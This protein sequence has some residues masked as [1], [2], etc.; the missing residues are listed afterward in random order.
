MKIRNQILPFQNFKKTIQ[1]TQQQ[2]KTDSANRL[3][4]LEKNNEFLPIEF[5][6]IDQLIVNKIKGTANN[7]KFD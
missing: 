1:N 2:D 4:F 3:V 7:Q 6:V 5:I